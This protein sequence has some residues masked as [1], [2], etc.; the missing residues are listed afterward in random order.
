MTDLTEH[1]QSALEQARKG[2]PYGFLAFYILMLNKPVPPHVRDWTLKAFAWRQEKKPAMIWASRGFTKSTWLSMLGAYFL[3][4]N[5]AGSGLMIRSNQNWARASARQIMRLVSQEPAWKVIFPNVVPD[6]DRGWSVDQGAWLKD[7]TMDYGQWHRLVGQETDATIMSASYDSKDVRGM[8]PRTWMF[9]DDLHDVDNVFSERGLENCK[10]IITGTILNTLQPHF[11]WEIWTATPWHESD[12]YSML[13]ETGRYGHII[14]PAAVD[15]QGKPSWPGTPVWPEGVPAEYIQLRFEA[16]HTGGL[17]ARRELLCDISSEEASELRF[18]EYPNELVDLAW[19]VWAG[20]DFASIP[21]PGARSRHRTHTAIAHLTKTPEGQAVL[22]GGEFGQW[23]QGESEEAIVRTQNMFENFQ[24]AAFENLG[25]GEIFY[26]T[27]VQRNPGVHVIPVHPAFTNKMDRI[28]TELGPHLRNGSLMISDK[29]TPFLD[30]V[31][32]FCRTFPIT[33]HKADPSWDAMDALYHGW[34][35]M[36][37][38]IIRPMGKQ[39]EPR[40]T[41]PFAALGKQHHAHA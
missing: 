22:F 6:E 24:V 2:G 27:F 11:P 1:Q 14:T 10:Q 41:N 30:L 26:E 12:G 29:R 40:V 23:T 33:P 21:E 28:H 7:Q 38:Q 17:L 36:N 32:R 31:R 18:Q 3:G 16:D 9:P 5:P 19:P 13:L 37:G 20:I 4:L 34:R 35:L 8:H 39:K 25:K 15:E